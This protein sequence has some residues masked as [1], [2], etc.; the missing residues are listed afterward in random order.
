MK[1][2][3]PPRGPRLALGLAAAATLAACSTSPLAT[4][5]SGPSG[6]AGSIAPDP[7][8]PTF[9]GRGVDV[10]GVTP[11]DGFCVKDYA[12]VTEARTLVFAPNGDLFVGA[13]SMPSPG[14]S[15]GGP[16]GIVL[17]SDDDR[18]GV[19]EQHKFA[20]NI[21]DVHGLALGGGFLY[22]T[23]QH[24]VWS[25]PYTLGQRAETMASRAKLGL[26]AAYS[27]GGRWT[28]GLAL[29]SKSG[30]LVTSRGEFG[31][32]GSSAGGEVSTVSASGT[33]TSIATGFRNPMY[34][35]CHAGDDL[36]AATELGE[37]LA[38]GAREKLLLLR[39]NTVYGYP[40][41]F[42]TGLVSDDAT[43]TGMSCGNVATE[44]AAFTLSD[45]P[46]GFDWEPGIWPAPFAGGIFVALHGSAYSSPMWAG[47]RVVYATT[48][49]TT[50]MPTEKWQDFLTGFGPD[51]T[52]LDRPT[53]IAFSPDGRMF[54][55]DDAS[56]R[57]FWIA[58]T[59]LK[60]P[61]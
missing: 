39:P 35:R 53:D 29:S 46:F 32:C 38:T 55:A 59:S 33:L 17:L 11:P 14:G 57:V 7:T 15:S 8:A 54:L 16:G 36:C 41:C 23:T 56:G 5:D 19:A 43:A 34:L 47:A 42:T 50:H 52:V 1:N 22:F 21:P 44:D 30:Q 9:C 40:C 18:D 58:P 2:I 20:A 31:T 26:P 4:P 37:D 25:T 3:L 27:T 48:D 13:P 10:P 51:G 28:H 45:T 61:N 49:P 6:A 12:E 24:D 60:V